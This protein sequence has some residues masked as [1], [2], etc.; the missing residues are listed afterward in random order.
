M[1]KIL[2]LALSIM[3]MSTSAHA[4][5]TSG[6]CNS[7]KLELLSGTHTSA[8]TYKAALFTST[9]TLS[10]AT[11]AYSATNEVSGTGYTAGGATL[12]GFSAALSS[13]TAVLTFSN[14]SWATSTITARGMLIYNSS[15]SNKA[16][17]VFN[18]G[19]DVSSSA[20][21]FSVTMPTADSTSGL[22]RIAFAIGAIKE[23]PA[24]SE[25][26][27]AMDNRAVLPRRYWV[28]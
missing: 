14:V 18:F 22:I 2:L 19:S 4:A 12:S 1:K 20:G 28:G 26:D 27:I 7:Y 23:D 8:N 13:S 5:I 21:T 11:T 10:N 25:W 6:L 17:A 16:V 3:I 15:V 9:A 24:R